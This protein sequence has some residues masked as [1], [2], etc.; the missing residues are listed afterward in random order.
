MRCLTHGPCGE[1]QTPRIG[2]RKTLAAR[3]S[4]FHMKCTV[5][6]QVISNLTFSVIGLRWSR[7]VYRIAG[8]NKSFPPSM[9]DDV[10]ATREKKPPKWLAIFVHITALR[11]GARRSWFSSSCS[12]YRP[13]RSTTDSARGVH[14]TTRQP[15]VPLVPTVLAP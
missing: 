10:T 1:V 9:W 5:A 7:S 13:L 4:T 2:A 14:V 12:D 8:D 3:E 15:T 6:L 11:L